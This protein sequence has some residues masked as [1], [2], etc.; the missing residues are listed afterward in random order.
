MQKKIPVIIDCDPGHDDAIAL[1]M[2]CCAEKLDIRGVTTVCGN[3]TVDKTTLNT[4]KILSFLGMKKIPVAKGAEKPLLRPLVVAAEVHGESGLGGVILPDAD[5]ELQ[6][7]SA[8]EL[9]KRILTESKVPV[10]M[11]CTAPLTNMALF[12]MSCPELIKNISRIVLMGGGIAHGNKTAA[13]EF[14]IFVDPEAAAVVFNSGIPIVMCPLDMTEKALMTMSEIKEFSKEQGKICRLASDIFSY[15]AD[16]YRSEGFDGIALHDP[17]TVAYLMKPELFTT[18]DMYIQIETQGKV[19]DG[20]TFADLRTCSDKPAPN[21][22]VCIQADRAAFIRLV[23]D[24]CR[25][26]DTGTLV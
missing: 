20:M 25:S 8:L 24:C 23:E 1:I 17:T 21:V 10:T 7:D 26:Y 15:Y 19:T 18:R 22:T 16:Y 6:E 3:Q 12:I 9:M 4:L 5:M 14:N 2:A 13:A 11:V